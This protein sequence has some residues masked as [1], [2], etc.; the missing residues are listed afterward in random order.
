MHCCAFA[1]E[2]VPGAHCSSVFLLWKKAFLS[3][4]KTVHP[5]RKGG[6]HKTEIL[7]I[8]IALSELLSDV[9]QRCSFFI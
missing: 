6:D 3:A 9:I 7:P 2:Y 8:K 1:K 4:R 5:C